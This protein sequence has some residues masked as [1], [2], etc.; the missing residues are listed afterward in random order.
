[1]II[2]YTHINYWEGEMHVSGKR[3]GKKVNGKGYVEIT[4]RDK[5]IYK[6][7]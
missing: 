5:P 3:C 2:K 1:M 7:M 4:G 6:S